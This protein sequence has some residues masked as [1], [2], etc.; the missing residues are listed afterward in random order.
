MHFDPQTIATY[1]GSA[2]QYAKKFNGIGS[3]VED[4]ERGLLLAG[5]PI[6][7]R[8]LEIGCGN[9]RDAQK[10]IKR[11]GYYVGIDP[12]EGLL[13]FARQN[14]PD[15]EFVT[16]DALSFDYPK[17]LD[18]AFAFASL[19]HV[20]RHGMRQ[21][22]RKLSSSLRDGAIAYISLKEREA[23]GQE[24][25]HDDTGDRLF[26]YYDT[27]TV[28]ETAGSDFKPVYDDHQELNGTS[29]LT[30]ALRKI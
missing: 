15:A 1:D 7:A 24:V 9:G 22:F 27:P 14:T 26:F 2:A 8:V 25:L 4:I 10:I 23:Y 21:V 20:D 6:G 29:W 28:I 11:A 16:S 3:R 30:L 12:S 13:S 18:V 17:Q 5:K 19:L